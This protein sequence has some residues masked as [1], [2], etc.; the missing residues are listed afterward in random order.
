MKKAEHPKVHSVSVI[1]NEEIAQDTWRIVLRAPD[2]AREIQ[3]GQFINLGVPG[4]RRHLLRLPF[5]PSRTCTDEG[6]L[7]LIYSVV[8]E[9]TQRLTAL[10]TCDTSTCIGPLGNGWKL[11]EVVG[12]PLLAA[13]G[14]GLAPIIFAAEA[15]CSTYHIPCDA[16]IAAKSA[17]YLPS[18]EL[19]RLEQVLISVDGS[20]IVTTDDGSRGMAGFASVG[21][22]Q[23]LNEHSYTNI[24]CC[25]PQPMMTAIA[26]LA[27]IHEI[28]CQ[29]SLERMMGCGFGACNCCSVDLAD[30]RR[31]ACCTEGPVFHAREVLM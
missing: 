24:L 26:A 15:I 21:V 22:E 14:A 18:S 5:A 20:L 17:S 29:V 12:R 23:L 7:D 30:G 8:G 13:G 16:V 10:K 3:A 1:S 27:A 2:L 4:D 28:E 19:G 9:G 11:S 31:V 6:T 25:G